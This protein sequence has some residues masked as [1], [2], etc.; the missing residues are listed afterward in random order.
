MSN[1]RES[2]VVDTFLALTD[3]LVSEFDPLDLPHDAR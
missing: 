1:S 2:Q 3:T